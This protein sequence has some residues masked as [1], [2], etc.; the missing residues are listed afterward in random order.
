MSDPEGLEMALYLCL[1]IESGCR[2]QAVRD[3]KW[4]SL[5]KQS[6]RSL[7]GGKDLEKKY[8]MKFRE[9]KE[10]KDI[11]TPVSDFLVGLWCDLKVYCM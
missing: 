7:A 4:N 9:E 8:I 5:I 6:I 1:G 2:G 11:K 3:V 10:S